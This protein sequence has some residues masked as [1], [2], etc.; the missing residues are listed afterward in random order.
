MQMR[1]V[2]SRHDKVPAQIH[3]LGL[4]PLKLFLDVRIFPHRLNP[5]SQYRN[6]FLAQDRTERS[7]RRSSGINISVNVDNVGLGPRHQSLQL[8]ILRKREYR[9]SHRSRHQKLREALHYSPTPASVSSVNKIRFNPS[10]RP[11]E[12]N[13]SC[14]VCAPPPDPPPPIAIAS[15]P[16]DSGTFASVEAL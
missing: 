4:R 2:K 14:K 13:H 7:I 15:S 10:S 12:S 11:L 8:R 3:D 6:R 1:V 16:I 9:N 5:I